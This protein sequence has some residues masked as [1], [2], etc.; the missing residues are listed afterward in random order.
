MRYYPEVGME[1][2]TKGLN[3]KPWMVEMLHLNPSYCSWGPGEDYMS[4]KDGEGWNSSKYFET[5]KE[6]GPWGLDEL[7]EVVNFYFEVTRES[8]RCTACDQTGYNLGTL[9]IYNG[10][11]SHRS[12]TGNGWSGELAQDEVDALW[13]NKRLTQYGTKPTAEQVNE[14]YN[15]K[16]TPRSMLGHDSINCSICVRAR[17]ERL[18]VFGYCTVCNGNGSVY[19]APEA[20]LGLTLWM[21]HP[22]KG[23]SKGINI[24]RIR[25]EEIP[26]VLTYLKLAMDR[27][28]KRFMGV[29][30]MVAVESAKM[31]EIPLL[32][33]RIKNPLA[34]NRLNQR[35]KEMEKKHDV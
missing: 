28:T 31:D 24:K 7:N 11:Y 1:D 8:E 10:W 25:R 9:K 2:Q 14:D 29:E 16:R 4:G 6:F 32:L 17:A 13:E 23:C 19:T 21:L 33:G 5:W 18:G 15:D 35:L 20:G 3:A 34:L 30:E 12:E 22:R 26:A 27:N